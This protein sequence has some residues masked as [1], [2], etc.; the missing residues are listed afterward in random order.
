MTHLLPQINFENNFLPA[1]KGDLRET[2]ERINKL[3]IGLICL[4]ILCLKILRSRQNKIYLWKTAKKL[5]IFSATHESVTVPLDRDRKSGPHQEPIR[6]QDTLPCPKRENSR[7]YNTGRNIF[8]KKK[9]P[10]PLPL[11]PHDPHLQFYFLLPYCPCMEGL[12]KI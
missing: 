10:T 7:V 4:T 3:F 9:E 2:K 8:T 6:L 11:P 5:G 1:T 12:Y